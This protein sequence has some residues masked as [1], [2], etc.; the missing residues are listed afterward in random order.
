MLQRLQFYRE[1]AIIP[2]RSMR[3]FEETVER[4]EGEI[5]FA[6]KKQIDSGPIR[7]VPRA[8]KDSVR[9]PVAVENRDLEAAI[10]DMLARFPKTLEYLAK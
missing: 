8:P 4:A 1:R 5:V 6:L 7:Q 9:R 3:N 2:S 10:D